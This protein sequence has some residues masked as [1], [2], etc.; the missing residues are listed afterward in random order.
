[1]THKIVRTALENTDRCLLIK[2][3][4]DT[5]EGL[6]SPLMEAT[7]AHLFES[8]ISFDSSD[9]DIDTFEAGLREIF[10]AGTDALMDNILS[11]YATRAMLG[12]DMTTDRELLEK[13]PPVEKIL[14]FLGEERVA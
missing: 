13:L 2:S 4:Q 5:L 6:G 1:L 14:K 9:F 10:G 11:Y 8:G 3:I 7:L 12:G